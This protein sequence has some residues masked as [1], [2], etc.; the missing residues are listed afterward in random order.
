MRNRRADGQTGRRAFP[1][2]ARLPVRP[3]ARPIT[4]LLAACT[5]SVQPATSQTRQWRPEERIV[6]RD[7]STVFQVATTNDAVYAATGGGL[8][9][10]D[11]R[12]NRWLPPVTALEGY[13]ETRV[14]AILDDPSDGSLWIGTVDEVVHYMPRLQQF[15][16]VSVPQGVRA[17]MY[18]RSDPFGGLYI[19][20]PR[21][22]LS[23]SRGGG[24]PMRAVDLPPSDRWV[25]SSSLQ[26]VLQRFPAADAMQAM[27][28]SEPGRQYR[29]TSGAADHM[30]R[31]GY[32]GTNGLG[33]VRYD[34]GVARLE[35][36]PFGLL[37]DGV[38]AIAVTDGGVWVGT[39]PYTQQPTPYVPGFTWLTENLEDFR[40]DRGQGLAGY[41]F[42]E[43]RDIA[44]WKD[45]WWAAT[46]AGVVRLG[47]RRSDTIDR[48]GGLPANDTYALAT[49]PDGMW[50]ATSRGLALLRDD[51][52]RVRVTQGT[53]DVLAA[54]G[55][56]VWV[57]GPNG[58]LHVV[59]DAGGAARPTG[60]PLLR[61][62]IEALAVAD[63]RVVVATRDQ[64]AWRGTDG[65]WTRDTP[66]GDMGRITA[67]AADQDGVWVGGQLGLQYFRFATREFVRAAG[68]GDLPGVVT[69]LGVSQGFLWVGTEGGL[70]R[71]EKRAVGF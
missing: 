67:L 14:V 24:V 39:T 13:P 38:G 46:E 63:G 65:G 52:R 31:I 4:T 62:P 40:I 18:D 54:D 43:V 55:G 3:S 59:D 58:V 49:T 26:D 37:A 9:V 53:F 17:L 29:Y 1:G 34:A 33:L 10:H 6:L 69:D 2:P 20:T 11:T 36:M 21:D 47:G 19:R 44:R 8:I 68:P 25:L 30:N 12:F 22:W 42:Q 23:I 16:R 50:V 71:I 51:G 28:L 48:R 70:V 35:R 41:R 7:Y 66:F 32:F 57:G 45:D 15:D 5:V 56:T 60:D 64:L 61:E 27:A